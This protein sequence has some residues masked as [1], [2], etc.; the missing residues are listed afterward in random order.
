LT[1]IGKV[2]PDPASAQVKPRDA[3][4]WCHNVF[5][6]TP[7]RQKPGDEKPVCV[8]EKIRVDTTV[9]TV[10]APG[11]TMKLQIDFRFKETALINTK[12]WVD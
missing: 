8:G 12:Q 11:S 9:R 2:L 5:W 7:C 3:G 6:E 1:S 4:R 10:L